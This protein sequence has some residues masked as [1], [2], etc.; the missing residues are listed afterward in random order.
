M[1]IL[2]LEDDLQRIE[3][4][5][6]ALAHL[7]HDVAVFEKADDATAELYADSD[8]DLIFL[9]HDLGGESF[10][11]SRRDDTGA[12]VARWLADEDTCE[13]KMY[14]RGVS[15]VIHSMNP[16]GQRTMLSTLQDAGF[17]F[18]KIIPFSQIAKL[19]EEG[20]FLQ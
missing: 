12:A 1:K 18:T 3:L 5:Q 16:V 10:V 17:K 14:S 19:I 15:I 6:Q 8:Y 9:D 20:R 7:G 11:D 4:F 2:I 13:G